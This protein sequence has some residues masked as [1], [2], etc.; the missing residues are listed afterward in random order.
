MSDK[1]KICYLDTAQQIGGGQVGLLDIL[2]N[3]DYDTFDPWIILPST[4]PFYEKLRQIKNV[5]ICLT[6]YIYLPKKISE[7]EQIPIYSPFSVNILRQKLN[8]IR[9]HLVHSN[10]LNVGRYG[11]KAAFL[12]KIPNI[13]TFR[14]IYQKRKFNYSRFVENRILTYSNNVIF[15]SVR[16]AEILKERSTKQNILSIVNGIDLTK[17]SKSTPSA[18]IYQEYGI[19]ENRKIFLLPARIYPDKGHQILIRAAAKLLTTN[20]DLQIVFLGDEDHLFKGAKDQFNSE[21]VDQGLSK[22][23]SW[24]KY[25]DNIVPFFKNAFCVVLPSFSEGCPRVLLESLAAGTPIIGSQIDG[26]NEIIKEGING[27]GFRLKDSERLSSAMQR[28]L[29]LSDEQ[30]LNMKQQCLTIAKNEYDLKQMITKY[31]N[32]YLKLINDFSK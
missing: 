14:C 3:L 29:S 23:I 5:N 9:P 4:G 15:N 24:I 27:F 13:V 28:L 30:Y 21:A 11:S 25:T 10:H 6:K 12:N 16:G 17:F 20:P 8:E 18:N 31:Q 32:L 1:Y 7:R 26:I 22:N 19:P 2:G